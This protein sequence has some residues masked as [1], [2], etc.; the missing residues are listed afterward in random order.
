[1]Q[2]C[3]TRGA[4]ERAL[5]HARFVCASVTRR[6][7]KLNRAA[8]RAPICTQS[9]GVAPRPISPYIFTAA[10]QHIYF[11]NINITKCACPCVCYRN[12]EEKRRALS[13]E[14]VEPA[15][16]HSAGGPAG[17][18]YSARGA[19]RRGSCHAR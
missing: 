19:A 13:C 15:A 7:P 5:I 16:A 8:A 11:I 18:V 12:T 17:P 10:P 1:M 14:L 4:S 9:E 2:I 6:E 3:I